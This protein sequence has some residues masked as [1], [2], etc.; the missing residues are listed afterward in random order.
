[1]RLQK[2]A[3]PLLAAL[4]LRPFLGLFSPVHAETRP[5]I[6]VTVGAYVLNLSDFNVGQGTFLADFYLW[7]SWQGNWS[8]SSSTATPLPS[9]FELMNGAVT[10]VTLIESD[11]NLSGGYHYL[12]Y[13][14]QAS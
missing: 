8:S 6:D 3:A 5:P 7:F 1:M 12:I 14:I 10:K 4:L 11:Q 9:D 2:L 13:R